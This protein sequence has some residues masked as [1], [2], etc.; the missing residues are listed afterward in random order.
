MKKIALSNIQQALENMGP[1]VR[2]S[3]AVRVRAKGAV[4]RMLAI[5]SK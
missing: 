3:E 5:P 4:E 2:V 1:E